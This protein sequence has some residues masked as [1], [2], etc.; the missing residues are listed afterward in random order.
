MTPWADR[1]R[2]RAFTSSRRPIN[3]ITCGPSSPARRRHQAGGAHEERDLLRRVVAVV[4]LAAPLNPAMG[5][6]DV[7]VDEHLDGA[8]AFA[9]IDGAPDQP[10]RHRVED[11][12]DFDVAVRPD[13][14]G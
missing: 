10:P 14:R 2:C 7:S 8:L 12:A 13:L 1:N 5:L 3:S 4:S 11:L 6:D 9:G